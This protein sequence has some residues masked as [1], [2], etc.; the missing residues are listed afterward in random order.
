VDLQLR[1]GVLKEAGKRGSGEGKQGSRSVPLI[2]AG[3]I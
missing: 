2:P 1:A 3:R